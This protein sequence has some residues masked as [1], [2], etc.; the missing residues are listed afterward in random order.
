MSEVFKGVG[1]HVYEQVQEAGRRGQDI[2]YQ[3]R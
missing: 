3:S 1:V 2:S